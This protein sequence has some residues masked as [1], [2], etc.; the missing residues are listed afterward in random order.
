MFRKWEHS[1]IS[2]SLMDDSRTFV[3]I[4]V[5]LLLSFAGFVL[6]WASATMSEPPTPPSSSAEKM[7]RERG[8]RGEVTL[9]SFT[10]SVKPIITNRTVIGI[11][12][13]LGIGIGTFNMLASQLGRLL[14]Y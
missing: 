13:N 5:Q 6:A 4:F 1:I 2:F 14:D 8:A 12:V 11:L 9:T 3:N 7:R 10:A